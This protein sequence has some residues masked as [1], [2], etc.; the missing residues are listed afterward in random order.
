MARRGEVDSEEWAASIRG[1]ENAVR[2]IRD[3]RDG[4]N[5]IR[6]IDAS[7]E[8]AWTLQREHFRRERRIAVEVEMNRRRFRFPVE[9]GFGDGRVH[10]WAPHLQMLT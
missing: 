5:A 2:V 6:K 8:K 3:I 10:P 9:R 7:L 1:A 4:G